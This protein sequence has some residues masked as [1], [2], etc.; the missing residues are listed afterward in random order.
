MPNIIVDRDTCTRCG[1]CVAVCASARVYQLED[2]AARPVRPEDCW[3]CG[4]CVAVCPVDAIR[5]RDYP[6]ERCPALESLPSYQELVAALRSRRSIRAFRPEPVPRETVRQL[7]DASRWAPSASNR[8]PVDW[9]AIDDPDHI[10]RL[11]T[12]VATTMANLARLLRSRLLRPFLR[13]FMGRNNVAHAVEAADK[14]EGLAADRAGGADPIFYHAPVVLVAHV[15]EKAF[16]G[17]DD[18]VYAAYNLMLAAERLGLGTCHI[19]YVNAALSRNRGLRQTLGLP[20]GRQLEVV[21]TLGYPR[22][23]FHR[24]LPRRR[25]DILWNPN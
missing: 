10:A 17:R 22:F 5:H 14:L 9:I 16:F 2:G 21:L 18:A 15:P 24:A 25:M 13:L 19:G 6:L 1:A 23:P 12:E 8:Q 20:E 7:V 4:H 11:S 3:S